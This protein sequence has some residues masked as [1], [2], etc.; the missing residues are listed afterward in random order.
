ML[1]T[2]IIKYLKIIKKLLM[3]LL[4][5]FL[6]SAFCVNVKYTIYIYLLINTVLFLFSSQILYKSYPHPCFPSPIQ[7]HL[8]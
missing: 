2:L 6:M 3:L 1:I 8:P 5:D 4:N 7:H